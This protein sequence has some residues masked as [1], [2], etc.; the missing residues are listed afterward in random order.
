MS[1]SATSVLVF[2]IYAFVLGIILL[3]APNLLLAL[4]GIPATNEVGCRDFVS[5]VVGM[6]SGR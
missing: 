4:F 3:F 1:K 6:I 5:A 2:G